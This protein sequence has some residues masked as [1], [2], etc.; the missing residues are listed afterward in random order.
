M[1]MEQEL[2]EALDERDHPQHEGAYERIETAVFTGFETVAFTLDGEYTTTDLQNFAESF[3]DRGLQQDEW[4]ELRRV[5]QQVQR[6]EEAEEEP[7]LIERALAPDPQETRV[8]TGE[9]DGKMLALIR[10]THAP[11]GESEEE[12]YVKVSESEDGEP[13]EEE[14]FDTAEESLE[15]WEELVEAYDF[16]ERAESNENNINYST[17]DE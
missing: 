6:E 2:L 8:A 13:L 9:V 5:E 4:D 1:S 10:V 15:Y 14:A 16:E 7:D 11:V 12:H 3:I 17:V